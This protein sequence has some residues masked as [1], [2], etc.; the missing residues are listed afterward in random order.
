[1]APALDRD[2]I[3]QAFEALGADLAERGLLIEIAVY[4]GGAL[5]LQFAWRRGTDDI[6]AVVRE[7]FDEAALAPS[8]RRV[9]ERMGLPADWLNDAVGMYT[10]LDED[11][12]LFL[13]A[14]SYPADGTPGL[15]TV[16]AK[17][18]Y[19]LAMKL[20]ALQTFDRGDRDL[21][22]AAALAK[23]LGIADEAALH[24]LYRS[25]YDEAPPEEAGLRFKAVLREPS[26]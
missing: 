11:E 1:M 24:A 20:Q 7:G 26:A 22:D 23:H 13:A 9:A 17:P 16:L 10:P 15:R 3:L 18:D 6:D 19:L 14:G 21:N 12:G 25:I 4:G 8:V 5:M 2:R